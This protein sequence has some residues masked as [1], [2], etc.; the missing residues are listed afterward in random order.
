MH[1]AFSQLR[2]ILLNEFTEAEVEVL[3]DKVGISFANLSGTGLFGKTRELL[4]IAQQHNRLDQLKAHVRAMRPN[5]FGIDDFDTSPEA[6]DDASRITE[7]LDE[8]SD[9]TSIT[10]EEDPIA[11]DAPV[12]RRASRG[13][14][15]ETEQEELLSNCH[16][17]A[18]VDKNNE[19]ST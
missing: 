16:A 5:A 9:Q 17:A 8:S 1:S 19:T 10:D 14:A 7:E 11:E 18:G 3:C 15:R 13:V 2:E 12:N 6:G 4:L